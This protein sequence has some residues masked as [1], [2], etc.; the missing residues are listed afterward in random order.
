MYTDYVVR[1]MQLQ[2][3]CLMLLFSLIDV[4]CTDANKLAFFSPPNS[5]THTE[6]L[7]LLPSDSWSREM[8][9]LLF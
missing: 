6:E 4:F 1:W 7:T 8:S 3:H 2:N 9:G 5:H